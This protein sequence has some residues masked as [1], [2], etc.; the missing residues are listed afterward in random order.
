[1]DQAELQAF[2]NEKVAS[3]LQSDA[4][5]SAIASIMEEMKKLYLS[6][7]LIISGIKLRAEINKAYLDALVKNGFTREEAIE[8]VLRAD[9]MKLSIL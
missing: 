8:F 4:V 6:K 2:M 5:K 1:M 7:P 3:D 9:G